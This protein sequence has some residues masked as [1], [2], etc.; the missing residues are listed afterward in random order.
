MILRFWKRRFLTNFSCNMRC[1]NCINFSF[2]VILFFFGKLLNKSC[3]F[4]KQ[5]GKT[6]SNKT[7]F[8]RK[9]DI[10]QKKCEFR[11]QMRR[12]KNWNFAR[13]R[14]EIF[15]IKNS[16]FSTFLKIKKKCLWKS[17]FSKLFAQCAPKIFVRRKLIVCFFKMFKKLKKTQKTW[18]FIWQN[19][20]S[21]FCRKYQIW[22]FF[23]DLWKFDPKILL[24]LT[25]KI[26]IF[27]NFFEFFQKRVFLNILFSKKVTNA[28]AKIFVSEKKYV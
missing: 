25:T 22:R 21:L 17:Y 6:I 16:R 28:L 12:I 19:I 23:E 7:K 9:S 18:N 20:Q 14:W 26:L 13:K 27:L 10:L 15:S 1:R 8:H 4:H 5:P 24:F 3:L 11:C 2:K